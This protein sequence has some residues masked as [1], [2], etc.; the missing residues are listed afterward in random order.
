MA[1]ESHRTGFGISEEDEVLNIRTIEE[2]LEHM[3]P[4]FSK[5]DVL[6]GDRQNVNPAKMLREEIK[7]YVLSNQ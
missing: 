7:Q 4:Y 5:M 6:F 1:R 3:C 2:K